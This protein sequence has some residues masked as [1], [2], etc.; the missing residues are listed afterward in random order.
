MT[1]AAAGFCAPHR[2]QRSSWLT[3]C[4]LLVVFYLF[5]IY[6]TGL[7]IMMNRSRSNTFASPLTRACACAVESLESRVMLSAYYVSPSGSD[8]AA[9]VS[10]PI[11]AARTHLRRNNA[12]NC[13]SFGSRLTCGVALRTAL[14]SR[15]FVVSAFMRPC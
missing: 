14:T 6:L 5:A 12:T 11:V 2:P 3:I 1:G 7:D 10:A 13:A 8:S 15:D 9:A 4:T